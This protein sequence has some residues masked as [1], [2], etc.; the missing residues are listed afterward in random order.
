[1]DNEKIMNAKLDLVRKALYPGEQIELYFSPVSK[2]LKVTKVRKGV[3][4]DKLVS[5]EEGEIDNSQ[6]M[7]CLTNKRLMFIEFKNA[8]FSSLP[9]S[10]S[11]NTFINLEEVSGLS[12][13]KYGFSK[14]SIEIVN[15]NQ[16]L[17]V[18][19]GKFK[20]LQVFVSK[21]QDYLAKFKQ[22]EKGIGYELEQ[23]SKLAKEGLITQEEWER[24]KE[25]FLG[26]QQSK[27]EELIKQLQSLFEL[28]KKGVLS[29]SEFNTK[30]WEVL[31]KK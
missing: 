29:E 6:I 17:P 15:S 1:M 16:A 12:W 7:I 26:N 10:I 24:A 5:S 30:K 31:S 3:F 27:Q 21:L 8:L 9:K 28:Y 20:E 22:S 4:G 23:L 11:G 13:N 14:M 2:L 19:V 25:L 18:F